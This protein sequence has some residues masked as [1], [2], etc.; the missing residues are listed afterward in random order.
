MF[1]GDPG[2]VYMVTCKDDCKKEGTAYGAGIYSDKSSICAA[3]IHSD[4]RKGKD[5][6]FNVVITYG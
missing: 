3:A 6:L 4:V 2:S 5:E 1:A